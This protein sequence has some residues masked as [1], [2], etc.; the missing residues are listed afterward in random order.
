MS[1]LNIKFQLLVIG[2]VVSFCGK[3][4]GEKFARRAYAKLIKFIRPIFMR[5]I[6]FS[7]A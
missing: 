3:F 6:K 7:A 4:R 1:F 5:R 2:K